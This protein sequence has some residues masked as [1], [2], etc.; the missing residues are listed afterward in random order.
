MLAS[1]R[2]R[3]IVAGGTLFLGALV[4]LSLVLGVVGLRR[5]G[6][7]F[8][9]VDDNIVPSIGQLGELGSAVE[10]VRSRTA[11]RLI[12][13]DQADMPLAKAD[14]AE[15]I[16]DVDKRIAAYEAK[17]SDEREREQ[18]RAV[19]AGWSTIRSAV[20]PLTTSNRVWTVEEAMALYTDQLRP[21]AKAE[22]DLLVKEL[23]YNQQLAHQRND[24]ATA[25]LAFVQRAALFLA[26]AAALL[27]GG[28]FLLFRSRLTAPLGEL[29]ATMDRMAAGELDIAVPGI[30]KRDELGEIARALAGIKTSIT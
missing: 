8:D 20:A 27:V 7:A 1:L 23:D 30:A 3:T 16:A 22:H 19:K 9:Y 29:C 28:V 25:D 26:V 10:L 18:F 2:I 15:A 17:V 4:A 12:E 11:A 5:A 21:A 24:D 14:L 6:S 13:Q